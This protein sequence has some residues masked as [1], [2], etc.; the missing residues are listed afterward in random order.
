MSA[1][2]PLPPTFV[3]CPACGFTLAPDA[4]SRASETACPQCR[5][6]LSGG[7]FPAFWNPE[8]VAFSLADHA[9]DGE[10]VCFFHPENRAALSCGS[11]R[12]KRR[13]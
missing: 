6:L 2:A 11:R 12:I 4:L 3:A 10:A 1:V 9:G 8:P 5:T 13:N 7:L